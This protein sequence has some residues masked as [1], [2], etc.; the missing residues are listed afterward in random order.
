MLQ[1]QMIYR[2]KGH[3]NVTPGSIVKEKKFVTYV[4]VTVCF[5]Q[6]AR[7]SFHNKETQV[8]YGRLIT[9]AATICI[10]A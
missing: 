4:F 1:I 7:E 6:N 8:D 9:Q 5:S 10:N 3:M 2:E